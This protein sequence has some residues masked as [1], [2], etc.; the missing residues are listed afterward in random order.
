MSGPFGASQWMY[1]SGGFYPYTIDQSVRFNDDDTAML[2]KTFGSAGNSKTWTWSGWVKRGNLGDTRPFFVAGSSGSA[3]FQAALMTYNSVADRIQI[4]NYNGSYNLRFATT[5]L[6]RDVSG[7]YHIVLK[8]DTTQATSTDRFKLYINGE[9]VTAF[10]ISTYP[11]QNFDTYVSSAASHR[12]GRNFDSATSTKSLDGYLAEVNFIDGTALD[13]TSFGETR[14]GIWIPKNYTGSYG[15]NGFKLAFQDSAS[16]GDDTSGNGHD[17]T[18]NNLAATDQMLDTPTSNFPTMN[19]LWQSKGTWTTAEGNLQNT[20]SANDYQ[21]GIATM[22]L[23][24]TGKWYWEIYLKS[25]TYTN[26]LYW[27]LVIADYA[28]GSGNNGNSASQWSDHY[29]SMSAERSDTGYL[30]VSSGSTNSIASSGI[31]DTGNVIQVAFDADNK[32]LYLGDSGTWFLSADPGAESGDGTAVWY[33]WSDDAQGKLFPASNV[34][35]FTYVDVQNFGQD[36]TFAG[37]LASGGNADANGIG[38][39]KYSVPSGYLALCAA[40]LPAP[41]IDPAEDEA[42]EDYFNTVTWS[43]TGADNSAITISDVGFK[44]DLVWAKGRSASMSH[45]WYDIVRGT[46]KGLSSDSSGAEVNNNSSGYISS[47]NTD[48]FTASP[49]SADNFYFNYQ[50]G[51]TYVA[52]NWKAGG[53]AVS[54][55]DGSIT[56]S[57]SASPESGFSIVTYSGNGTAGATIGHGLGKAPDMIILK[58]RNETRNWQVYH[59]GNTSAPETDK[60]TLNLTDPTVD[61]NTSWNDTAPSSSVFTVGTS[62]G[63]NNSSGT[64]VAYCFANIDGMVK[65][66][67]YTGNGSSDGPMVHTGFRPA[68]VMIKATGSTGGASNWRV[69]DSVR[70]TFNPEDKHLQPNTADA[71]DTGSGAGYI[72]FLSNG[73]KIRATA[74]Q[75]NSSGVQFVYLAFA[76]QP[77][78]YA[79]AR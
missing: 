33:N 76:E 36:S 26:W 78:K 50:N 17:F 47:F 52:W 18:A 32:R 7:W 48:G 13:A 40:N 70:N 71:E 31:Y 22:G 27:N 64:Y 2:S 75:L 23:P 16:L 59:S 3:I 37:N 5:Q 9:A 11:S 60:L 46:G 58:R 30:V 73:F 8:M 61:D 39:F 54:N 53:T 10:E 24:A 29:F 41:G 67:S 79:N 42:P 56:S 6:F 69:V 25:R 20:W 77:L 12:I 4:Y 14:A 62:N 35:Y 43:K 45:Q 15:T 38:D 21:S 44:P 34:N 66:G 63:T 65:A 74:L 55:T 1:Q 49:G 72:D 19:K 51:Y 57:V 68:W 28:E